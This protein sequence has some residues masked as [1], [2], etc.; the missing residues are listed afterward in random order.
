MWEVIL[1][2]R[3]GMELDHRILK[4]AKTDQ[5]GLK[6]QSESILKSVESFNQ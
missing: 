2:H 6:L 1:Q 5:A 3:G 4:Q